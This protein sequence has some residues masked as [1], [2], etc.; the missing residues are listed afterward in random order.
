MRYYTHND[1]PSAPN[2]GNGGSSEKKSPI[3]EYAMRI[4]KELQF[5]KGLDV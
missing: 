5:I 3:A 1:P 4:A 2:D